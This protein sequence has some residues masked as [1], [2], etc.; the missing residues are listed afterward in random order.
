MHVSQAELES[1][2]GRDAARA[3]T[4]CLG[5]TPVYVPRKPQPG[6]ELARIVGER[7][8][9][10]LCAEYGGMKLELPNGRNPEPRKAAVLE[11]LA[12]GMSLREAALACGVT[13]RYVCMLAGSL[14]RVRQLTL[15][16]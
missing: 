2:L 5:G 4:L 12:R 11:A 8:L 16:E 14:P 10:A 1:V 9:L 3:L 6:H 15:F 13:R 7:G